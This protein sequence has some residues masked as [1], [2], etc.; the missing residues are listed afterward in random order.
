MA[1]PYVGEVRIFA[2][3]FAP[4]G[5][6][7]CEGQLLPISE[8]ETLFQLIGTTYGGDGES[9]F[10]LPDLRGRIPIH[11]GNGFVLAETGG[12]EEITLT[13][14]QIP[15]HSHSFMGTNTNGSGGSPAGAV[16]ARNA[17]VDGYTSD[18]STGL[19][20]MSPSMVNPVGGSQPHTNFQPYLCV[21]FIISLFG[22]F[23]SPT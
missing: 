1:Q 14:Q 18:S 16:L 19:V 23:P 22:I 15:A 6:M 17:A 8:N 3:N 21:D 11:Q 12:A 5:W 10:A 4:A 20:S 2:G 7:F 13:T 9:T